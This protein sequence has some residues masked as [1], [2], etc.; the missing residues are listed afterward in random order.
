[1]EDIRDKSIIRHEDVIA[2]NFIRDT[3]DY[4]FRRHHL[5]GLR[6]HIMELLTSDD[7][8]KETE[9]VIVNGIQ[10]FPIA[11]PLKMLRIFRKRFSGFEEILDEIRRFQIVGRYLS[12][13]HLAMSEEFIVDYRMGK[14]RDILLCGLQEYVEGE[15]LDPW[16]VQKNNC[17]ENLAEKLAESP[18]P[19]DFFSK[20]ELIHRIEK[21]VESFVIQVKKMIQEARCVPDLAG[22]RNILVTRNGHVKLVDINN[23]SYISSDGCV[24][25]DDFNYPVCD[26]SIEALSLIE[27]KLL[28]RRLEKNDPVYISVLKPERLREVDRLALQF[29]KAMQRSSLSGN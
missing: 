28:G 27:Q 22:N 15:C 6:S 18:G 19:G 4:V 20:S 14:N 29:Q 5:N 16:T 11:K 1:M 9:G 13:F 3:G 17:L 25:M 10:R 12:S 26:K 21:S 7:V 23:I 24:L 2:L 8:I